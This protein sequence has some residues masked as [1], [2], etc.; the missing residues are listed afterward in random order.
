[1]HGFRAWPRVISDGATRDV[2][3]AVTDIV[4]APANTDA[5]ELRLREA[6][7]KSCRGSSGQFSK[8]W[9]SGGLRVFTRGPCGC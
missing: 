4:I 3:A 8:V 1:V 5:P 2:D 9:E 6:G 7:P